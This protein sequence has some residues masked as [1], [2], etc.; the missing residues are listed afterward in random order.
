MLSRSRKWFA[1]LCV[2]VWLV[3][4]AVEGNAQ[5]QPWSAFS[6]QLAAGDAES[7]YRGLLA[8]EEQHAGTPEFD[9][10]LGLAALESGR[11]DAAT[12][13]FERVLTIDPNFF[14]AR[15][16][17]ARAY[18]ALGNQ[19]LAQ[20]EFRALLD[21]DPPPA[22]R[23]TINA[24]LAAIEARNRRTSF[25][26]YAEAG[27]GYDTN[28]NAATSQATVSIPNFA[29]VT[30]DANS[31]ATEDGFVR[32]KVGGEI[33]HKLSEQALLRTSAALDYRDYL[34]TNGFETHNFDFGVGTDYVRGEDTFKLDA[35]SRFVKLDWDEYQLNVALGVQWQRVW[36]KQTQTTVF[37]QHNRIRY[38][39][40][41]DESNDSN[42]NLVGASVVRALDE[43]GRALLSAGGFFGVDAERNTRV[44]GS[45]ELF[46]G[47][48]AGQYGVSD[49][50]DVFATAGIQWSVYDRA[51]TVF[52]LRRRDLQ[53]DAALGMVWR[54]APKWSV[55]PQ[56]DVRRNL[57][58]IPTNEYER[59]QV[60]LTIRRDF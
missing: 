37:A 38:R 43:T 23:E 22:A 19:D 57:T 9:Y 45:R 2:S 32:G 18:F 59:L 41:A 25:S 5:S 60:G 16:D 17:M 36:D 11:P 40:A 29:T 20:E 7:A 44:D 24:Y 35:T 31:V 13:A 34:S 39:R 46:G 58:D 56:L 27:L 4:L 49:D 52:Q 10:L 30:L 14:G 26:Y 54:P 48:L 55:R 53:L 12:F 42:L 8:L 15:L 3:L 1:V 51:N 50:L 6:E 47:R 28:A 33:R 21:L